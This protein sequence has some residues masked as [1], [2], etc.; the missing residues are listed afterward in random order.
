MFWLL[1]TEHGTSFGGAGGSKFRSEDLFWV[2]VMSPIFTD[3]LVIALFE[4]HCCVV[5]L[6]TKLG[7]L[8]FSCLFSWADAAQRGQISFFLFYFVLILHKL[9]L[10]CSVF[11]VETWGGLEGTALCLVWIESV[12]NKT[13]GGIEWSSNQD[14][15]SGV[16]YMCCFVW[17][18]KMLASLSPYSRGGKPQ[19]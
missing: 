4:F 11:Q 7:L 16:S 1:S 9:F 5:R 8:G 18:R 17:F 3:F 2:W 15:V 6:L 13:A 14:V 19:V 10:F 12:F